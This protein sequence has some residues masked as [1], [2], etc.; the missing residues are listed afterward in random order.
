[1]DHLLAHYQPECHSLAGDQVQKSHQT[2]HS[3][4]DRLYSVTSPEM[5]GLYQRV[6][7]NR[8][9]SILRCLRHGV[10]QDQLVL[11]FIDGIQSQ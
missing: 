10:Y 9:E 11:D 2:L 3:F 1:M 4:W 8:M 5:T 7:E 6:C